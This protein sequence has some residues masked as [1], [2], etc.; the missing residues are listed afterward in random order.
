MADRLRVL[1]LFGGRSAEHDVSRVSAV[2]I[3]RALDPKRYDVVPVAITKEGRWLLAEDAMATLE[4]GPDALPEGFVVEGRAVVERA[5]PLKPE[6]VPFD[7]DDEHAHLDL[8]TV[9]G[10]LHDDPLV[11][12]QGEVQR[13][14]QT[15]AV[16]GLGDTH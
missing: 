1:L 9:D 6:L 8:A 16:L 2:S 3:A 15:G 5:D 10:F 4:K 11:E 7:P 13:R 12:S 14:L